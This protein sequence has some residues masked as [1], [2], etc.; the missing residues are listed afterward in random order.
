MRRAALFYIFYQNLTSDIKILKFFRTFIDI[1]PNDILAKFESQNFWH[2][3]KFLMIFQKLSFS[4]S[5]F[6]AFL[7]LKADKSIPF[8]FSSIQAL[9]F[10]TFTSC[11]RDFIA[12]LLNGSEYESQ[13]KL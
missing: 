7:D 10:I 12:H 11:N 2:I 3:W 1:F 13:A 6:W 8:T 4:Q 9:H 5:E